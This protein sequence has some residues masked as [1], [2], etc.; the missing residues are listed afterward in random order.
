M[1]GFRGIWRRKRLSA[2]YVIEK[3]LGRG[4]QGVV[5]QAFQ[6]SLSRRV[7]MKVLQKDSLDRPEVIERFQR[8]ILLLSRLRHPN[9]VQFYDSGWSD[10]QLYFTMELLE[11]KSLFDHLRERG[12][13]AFERVRSITRGVAAALA[14]LHRNG[15]VHRDVKLANVF[16]QTG[17]VPKLIDF[18]LARN[19]V[20][21]DLTAPGHLIG[22]IRYMP[23]ESLEGKDPQ[24][25]QDVYALG[26]MMWELVAG[27]P[28]LGE[29]T[30]S[31]IWWL[32]RQGDIPSI[33]DRRP[34]VPDDLRRL[35]QQCLS[36]DPRLR[37]SSEQVGLRLELA[38]RF[39]GLPAPIQRAAASVHGMMTNH[40]FPVPLVPSRPAGKV[41][42]LLALL[43]VGAGALLMQDRASPAV[44][45]VQTPVATPGPS[46]GVEVWDILNRLDHAGD[47]IESTDRDPMVWSAQERSRAR[48]G[49][50]A[51]AEALGQ[52]TA[53]LRPAGGIVDEEVTWGILANLGNVVDVLLVYELL[54]PGA[55]PHFPEIR[56]AR[57]RL[58][59][60]WRETLIWLEEGGLIPEG[61]LITA[62]LRGHGG[63][64]GGEPRRGASES[65]RRVAEV[66]IELAG[67]V[68]GREPVDPCWTR[69]LRI[70]LLSNA[71]VHLQQISR[72]LQGVLD[73]GGN[74][75]LPAVDEALLAESDAMIAG[76]GQRTRTLWM[77]TALI[78]AWVVVDDIM[79]EESPGG[80]P[81]MIRRLEILLGELDRLE[82][83]PVY[84]DRLERSHALLAV[85][86]KRGGSGP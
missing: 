17:D 79:L 14:E 13:L 51:L 86:R 57:E 75:G 59:S 38:L 22:T 84:H 45:L 72:G 43:G 8:E 18:G 27:S 60:R 1:I 2:S 29:A 82:L 81:R 48:T 41:L 74:G 25:S 71:R 39:R 24:P 31:T 68:T 73:P 19:P 30:E 76:A 20:G 78:L 49:L 34:D 54:D 42:L 64:A 21:S 33:R 62:F 3:E 53:T 15:L 77:R 5:Y 11:G 32:I 47:S 44:T 52:L 37:P 12:P 67:K 61:K 6:T 26:A 85:A 10:G 7:A 35:I 9:I 83:E 16:L 36:M 50:I 63:R 4:G 66:V 40:S 80:D 23:P 56:K 28:F 69:A 55:G 58:D 70:F 65:H 46:P